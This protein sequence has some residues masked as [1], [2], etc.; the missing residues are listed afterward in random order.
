MFSCVSCH[1]LFSVSGNNSLKLLN[2]HRLQGQPI[3]G[4]NFLTV[5]SPDKN[6]VTN[7]KEQSFPWEGNSQL[8]D[9]EI[10]WRNTKVH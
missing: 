7:S 1:L 9:Q 6:L 3:T 5:E 8:D 10:P 2:I 4:F